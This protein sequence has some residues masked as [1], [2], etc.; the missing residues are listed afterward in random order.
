MKLNDTSVKH[1]LRSADGL[2]VRFL[3]VD[4]VSCSEWD[5]KM[6]LK[7]VIAIN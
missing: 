5:K 3:L 1:I 2:H 6:L 7:A 4:F